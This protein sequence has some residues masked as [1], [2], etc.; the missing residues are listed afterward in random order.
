MMLPEYEYEVVFVYELVNVSTVVYVNED[1][2]GEGGHYET[3]ESKVVQAAQEKVVD[4]TGLDVI[5][6]ELLDV[7][8]KHTGT[9]GGN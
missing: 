6:S 8:V 3:I 5:L 1:Y 4:S 7:E 2:V 9:I